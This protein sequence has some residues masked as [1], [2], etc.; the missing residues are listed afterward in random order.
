MKL[1]EFVYLYLCESSLENWYDIF[2]RKCTVIHNIEL[3][4]IY[5]KRDREMWVCMCVTFWTDHK[6][7][8]SLKYFWVILYCIQRP[9]I[10]A[11]IKVDLELWIRSISILVN[12]TLVIR[13][14]ETMMLPKVVFP[15]VLESKL[16]S[17]Q[18]IYSTTI[19]LR[20]TGRFTA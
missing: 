14:M 9:K 6:H 5:I 13:V 10:Y 2:L 16:V 18:V 15:R 3:I 1:K 17:V 7:I 19:I 8:I 12:R 4:I 20:L 11:F